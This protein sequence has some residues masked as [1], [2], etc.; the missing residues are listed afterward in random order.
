[1]FEFLL[2]AAAVLTF[3]SAFGSVVWYMRGLQ[4]RVEALEA[5]VA[6]MEVEDA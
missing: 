2:D 3:M 1:M 4:A 5:V 6:S